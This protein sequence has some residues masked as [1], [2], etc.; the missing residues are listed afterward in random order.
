MAKSLEQVLTDLAIKLTGKTPTQQQLEDII[1]FMAANYKAGGGAPG[2]K[3]DPGVGIQTITGTIDG[4]NKL[5]L[6]FT[7]TDST[8]QTVEGNI[9]PPAA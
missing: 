3:G 8:Q 7:L 2:P 6:T 9:T 4:S 5:T 1:E